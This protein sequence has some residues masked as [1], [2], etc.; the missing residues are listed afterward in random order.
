MKLEKA[1]LWEDAPGLEGRY[2]VSDRGRVI[3]TRVGATPR[4]TY[5]RGDGYHTVSIQTPEGPRPH[6]VHRMVAGAF[7]PGYRPGSL[8]EVNHKDGNKDN[9]R[10]DN[11]EWV[12]RS[13]NLLHS[14]AI[15]R[16]TYERKAA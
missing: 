6:Y 13:E 2:L 10:A 12:T 9:N 3:S 16:R 8:I 4:R 15:G 7:V 1:E 14:I 5:K 11:L